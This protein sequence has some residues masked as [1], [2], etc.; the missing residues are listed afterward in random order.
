MNNEVDITY[1]PH[2][3]PSDC[4]VLISSQSAALTIAAEAQSLFQGFLKCLDKMLPE[5]QLNPEL[6]K[7]AQMLGHFTGKLDKVLA[8]EYSCSTQCDFVASG[9]SCPHKRFDK[10]QRAVTV[11]RI[12]VTELTAANQQLQSHCDELNE[13]VNT[14]IGELSK[15]RTQYNNRILIDIF[16]EQY[17][18]S[19]LCEQGSFFNIVP[20]ERLNDFLPFIRNIVLG[21]AISERFDEQV[22]LAIEP[23]KNEFGVVPVHKWKDVLADRQTRKVIAWI[24]DL[25]YER[26]QRREAFHS[27]LRRKSPVSVEKMPKLMALFDSMGIQ[28]GISAIA[29]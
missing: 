23:F 28:G 17:R 1:V 15:R 14:L 13:Q 20:R 29:C 27:I 6:K 19:D 7:G 8:Q 4:P 12:K 26:S 25:L 9:G 5:S 11:E 3:C 18:L 21:P 10:M 24:T 2:G 16:E 22:E